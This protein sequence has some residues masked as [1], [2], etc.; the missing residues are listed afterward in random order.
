MCVSRH[1]YLWHMCVVCD[2]ICMH[3]HACG[4]VGMCDY[5]YMCVECACMHVCVC[6]RVSSCRHLRRQKHPAQTCPRCLQAEAEGSRTS[7]SRGERRPRLHPQP[8]LT[9]HRARSP[10]RE[11]DRVLGAPP[12][13]ASCLSCRPTR[14]RLSPLLSTASRNL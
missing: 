3:V 7:V 5:E 1:T 9:P 11:T 13:R 8:H 2:Y 4:W 10:S 12:W 14:P 6:A